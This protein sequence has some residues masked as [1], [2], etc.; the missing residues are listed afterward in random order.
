[1]NLAHKGLPHSKALSMWF[2]PSEAS[3]FCPFV[4]HTF[5]CLPVVMHNLAVTTVFSL[6]HL[7][8][9]TKLENEILVLLAWW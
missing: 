3:H 9:D 6:H 7:A 8:Y 5:L 2:V 1:M 4:L